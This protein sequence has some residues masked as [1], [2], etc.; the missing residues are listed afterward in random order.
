MSKFTKLY[1]TLFI[2]SVLVFSGCG[3][4]SNQD[5]NVQNVSLST[6]D[7]NERMCNYLADNSKQ[8]ISGI[9]GTDDIDVTVTCDDSE[10]Y[11][12][13]IVVILSE[14]YEDKSEEIKENIEESISKSFTFKDIKIAFDKVYLYDENKEEV[15][16]TRTYARFSGCFT[17]TVEEL[18]P[19]YYALPGKTI[20]VVHFFQ[21]RPFLLRFQDDLTDKLTE[22][23]TY[24][25]EIDTF[26]VEIPEGTQSVDISDYMYSIVVTSYRPAEDNE[27]GLSELQATIEIVQK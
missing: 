18:L 3:K 13:D 24:V 14:G 21:D 20:A 9:D 16:D 27:K 17:A 15:S 23:E 8:L 19:D 12:I 6:D 10:E 4:I 5:D 11:S 25:F 1:F 2:A 7:P 26:E 22:G